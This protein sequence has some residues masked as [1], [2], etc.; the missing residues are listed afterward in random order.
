MVYPAMLVAAA[1]Q[2]L[3]DATGIDGD[4]GRAEALRKAAD[5]LAGGAEII[6]DM[7]ARS[8]ASARA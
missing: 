4:A 7:A 3:L 1:L 6:A 5:S 2:N 8:R